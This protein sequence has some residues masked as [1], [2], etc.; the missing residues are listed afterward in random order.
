[1]TALSESLAGQPPLGRTIG[2]YQLLE[3]LGRGGM[4]TVYRARQAQLEK[5]VAV[6]VL[7]PLRAGKPGAMTRF[8]REARAAAQIRHPHV[9]E[10]FDVGFDEGSAFLVMELLEG[11]DLAAHLQK[12]GRLDLPETIEVIAPVLAGVRAAH[13]AGVVHRDLKPSNIFLARRGRTL[14]NPVV[15]DFGVS[16][17]LDEEELGL[18]TVTSA[19]TLIGTA[20]YV[21]PEQ[22]K[23]SR[24]A[25]D[26]S[27]Q[28]ALGVIVYEC[29]T[30]QRPFQG[31]STFEL[32]HAIAT[33]SVQAPS[34]LNPSLPPALDE[35]LLR[36]L[37]RDPEQR[38]PDL[39][40]FSGALMA[41]ATPRTWLLWGREL[42]SDDGDAA[43]DELSRHIAPPPRPRLVARRDAPRRTSPG[44][45]LVAFAC[46]ALLS[47]GLALLGAPQQEEQHRPAEP[48]SATRP[49]ESAS[50]SPRAAVTP[51]STT[52]ATMSALA[53]PPAAPKP[54]VSASRTVKPPSIATSAPVELGPNDAPILE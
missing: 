2:R 24:M 7:D 42:A 30:G 47:A 53:L 37:S 50:S 26:R 6:K 32:L 40:A 29:V 46:G 45:L 43:E 27:D 20:A 49:V 19:D 15:L 14:V 39:D 51:T 54:R 16:R 4:G 38:F 21:A 44:R 28:Y 17:F 41:F 1:M 36:A 23:Q 31:A 35:V 13:E 34:A 33:A 12:R 3:V 18:S 5:L 11:L 8:L 48:P 10:V 25:D 9:V 52:A 22:A